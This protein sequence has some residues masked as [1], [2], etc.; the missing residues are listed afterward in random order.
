MA[1]GTSPDP[2]Y[3][4]ENLTGNLTGHLN[5]HLTGHLTG[6][7]FAGVGYTLVVV[8]LPTMTTMMPRTMVTMRRTMLMMT[9]V[10]L[11]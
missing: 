3:S 5:G 10:S 8:E 4:T 1:D 2:C 6:Q 11:E 9:M 7:L